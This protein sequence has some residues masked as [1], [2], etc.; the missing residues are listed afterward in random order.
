MCA[1]AFDGRRWQYSSDSAGLLRRVAFFRLLESL[2]AGVHAVAVGGGKSC[3][4]LPSPG[5]GVVL[6]S[7]NWTLSGTAES[8]IREDFPLESRPDVVV[9]TKLP[10]LVPSQPRLVPDKYPPC[11]SLAV[12]VPCVCSRHWRCA[13]HGDRSYGTHD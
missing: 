8:W 13:E 11:C 1:I 10:R 6:C 3:S 12:L 2:P 4:T 7:Y 9:V 5:V